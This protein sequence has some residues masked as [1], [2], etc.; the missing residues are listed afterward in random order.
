MNQEVMENT[1]EVDEGGVRTT[2]TVPQYSPTSPELW[3]A[4]VLS[5]WVG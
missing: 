4:A 3:D 1:Q 2:A 5:A